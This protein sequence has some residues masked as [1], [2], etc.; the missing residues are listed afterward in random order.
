M[1][2]TTHWAQQFCLG[3]DN[4][5]YGVGPY[6]SQ[7][8]RLR[9]YENSLPMP[10]ASISF[11]PPTLEVDDPGYSSV[12]DAP[13]Y[14]SA[15][16]LLLQPKPTG[17]VPRPSANPT[18][19]SAHMAQRSRLV[20]PP[21]YNF[22]QH[23]STPRPAPHQQWMTITNPD[24]GYVRKT[25]RMRKRPPP[26]ARQVHRGFGIDQQRPSSPSSPPQGSCLRLARPDVDLSELEKRIVFLTL[27]HSWYHESQRETWTKVDL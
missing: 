7:A 26:P 4:P 23:R 19:A 5:N 24:R 1:C 27:E 16:P 21:A 18:G 9:D 12:S 17:Y 11:S 3:C 8:C 20:L 22:Q 15:M 2:V 25:A 10:M 13:S 14:S 6:C